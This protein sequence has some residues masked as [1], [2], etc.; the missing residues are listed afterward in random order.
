MFVYFVFNQFQYSQTKTK[1][2]RVQDEKKNQF[3]S[4]SFVS[5]KKTSSKNKNKFHHYTYFLKSFWLNRLYAIL[6]LEFDF[7]LVCRSTFLWIR[8]IKDKWYAFVCWLSFRWLLEWCRITKRLNVYKLHDFLKKKTY[9][10]RFFWC[11]SDLWKKQKWFICFNL[12]LLSA[13]AVLSPLLLFICFCYYLL[14]N[15]MCFFASMLSRCYSYCFCYFHI[16]FYF[17]LSKLI[18]RYYCRISSL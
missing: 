11:E 1:K 13:R 2:G 18:M 15:Q 10:F 14:H 4:F 6:L 17:S 12:C 5:W 7:N 3:L 9:F 16:F 8:E